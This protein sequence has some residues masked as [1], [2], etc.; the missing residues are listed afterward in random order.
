MSTSVVKANRAP[1]YYHSG[2]DP[3]ASGVE[4]IGVAVLVAAA[5]VLIGIAVVGFRRAI[6]RLTFPYD[7]G[8]CGSCSSPTC[9]TR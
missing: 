6:T 3:I 2:D 8:A 9:T 4:P 1:F 7:P 5:L